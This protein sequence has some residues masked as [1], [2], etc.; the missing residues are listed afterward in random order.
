MS[1]VLEARLDAQRRAEATAADLAQ[2]QARIAAL[3]A[4][5]A[6]TLRSRADMLLTL[7]LIK[8]ATAPTPEDGGSHPIAYDLAA[9]AIAKA[10]EQA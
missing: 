10:G 6:T 3:T 8:H 1:A 9:G 5:L 4:E 7:R 2:A